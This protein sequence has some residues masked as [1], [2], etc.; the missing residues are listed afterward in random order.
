MNFKTM[1]GNEILLNLDN[2]ENLRHSELVG[3]LIALGY[4]DRKKEHDWNAHPILQKCLKS[5]YE[6]LP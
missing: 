1:S 2:Y 5:I 4:R 6:R 3:G